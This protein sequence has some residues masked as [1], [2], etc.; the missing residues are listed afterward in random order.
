MHQVEAI[1]AN[2]LEQQHDL[3]GECSASG[4]STGVQVQCGASDSTSAAARAGVMEGGGAAGW[5]GGV[6][7]EPLGPLTASWTM[8]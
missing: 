3:S 8:G 4:A 7:Q 2:L 5:Q 1:Q 6:Q